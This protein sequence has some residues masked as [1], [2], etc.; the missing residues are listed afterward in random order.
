MQ[1][2]A[3]LGPLLALLLLASGCAETLP[4][5]DM[6][7]GLSQEAVRAQIEKPPE[8]VSEFA[9]PEQPELKFTVLEY[10]LAPRPQWPEQP[11]WM[12]FNDAGLISFGAGGLREAKARAY[13]SYYDW[14]AAQ[15]DMPRTVAEQRFRETLERLYGAELNPMVDDYLL[16]R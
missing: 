3:A 7:S 5:S 2:G 9:L 12:L 4:K 16:Y 13:D 11:Y 15:G 1:R 14:M 6:R 8:K 10:L